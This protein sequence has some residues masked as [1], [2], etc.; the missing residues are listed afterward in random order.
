MFGGDFPSYTCPCSKFGFAL[1]TVGGRLHRETL[2]QKAIT[3][4]GEDFKV[5][6]SV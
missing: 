2:W 3:V 4:F 6:G 1:H 5:T